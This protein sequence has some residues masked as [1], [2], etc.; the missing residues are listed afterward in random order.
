MV[1][2]TPAPPRKGRGDRAAHGEVRR[3]PWLKQARWRQC[4][5]APEPIPVVRADY[6][7]LLLVPVLALAALPLIGSTDAPG[8]RSPSPR[9]PWA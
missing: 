5:N 1:D 7:P 3:R 2:P 9:S 6:L 8:S 4:A